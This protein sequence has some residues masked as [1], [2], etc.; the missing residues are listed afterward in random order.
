M[1]AINPQIEVSHSLTLI[2]KKNVRSTISIKYFNII[3]IHFLK[4]EIKIK[5]G[6]YS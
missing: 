6:E 1:T 4:E 5:I 3:K 2:Q